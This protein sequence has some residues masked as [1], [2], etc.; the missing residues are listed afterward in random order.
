MKDFI[1]SNKNCP[2]LSIRATS[3][4]TEGA[5]AAARASSVA[6]PQPAPPRSAK[7]TGLSPRIYLRNKKYQ[8]YPRHYTKKLKVVTLCL[9]SYSPLLTLNERSTLQVVT[10]DAE[11]KLRSRAPKDKHWNL[12]C[13]FQYVVNL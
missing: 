1:A 12:F 7:G 11:H 6:L 4:S 9:L 5:S 10:K 3:G 8:G 2:R 13:L